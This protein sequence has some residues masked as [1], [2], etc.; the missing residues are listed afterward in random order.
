MFPYDTS[1]YK[2]KAEIKQHYEDW[3]ES[4][5]VEKYNAENK[6]KEENAYNEAYKNIRN[7]KE[8]S[9]ELSRN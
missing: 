6:K 4:I 8:K 9:S 7:M 1:I 2:L 5:E 3:N